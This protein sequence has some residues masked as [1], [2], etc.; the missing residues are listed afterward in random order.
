MRPRRDLRVIGQTPLWGVYLASRSARSWTFE[1]VDGSMRQ[2]ALA[3]LAA[4]LGTGGLLGSTAA[5]PGGYGYDAY[6]APET[7]ATRRTVVERRVVAPPREVVR[8]VVVERSLV[9]PR[10]IVREVVEERPIVY[11]PR[12]VAREVVVER[13]GFYGPRR[14]GPR[15]VGY[16]YGP[17]F[18]PYD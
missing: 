15:P 7:V 17:A 18:D 3:A 2:I 11:R 6:D 10:R 12:P 9:R 8:E 16:G 4:A 14:F 5:Y 13:D 1:K